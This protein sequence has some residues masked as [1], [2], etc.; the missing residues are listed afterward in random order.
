MRDVSNRNWTEPILLSTA[1]SLGAS[2]TFLDFVD[3]PVNRDIPL[4]ADPF[5]LTCFPS[6][7]AKRA[8]NQ[9]IDFFSEVLELVQ[10]QKRSQ[11]IELLSAPGEA[12]D[13]HFGYSMR[14]S[15]RRGIGKIKAE[16]MAHALFKSEAAHTGLLTSLSELDLFVDG[17]ADDNISDLTLNI[18]RHLLI[19][20]TESQLDNLD[21]EGTLIVNAGFGWDHERK[22]WSPGRGRFPICDNERILL[23]PKF[24][25]R[26]KVALNPQNFY[27]H[28]M[29]NYI[30]REHESLG[31]SFVKVFKN[32]K[33]RVLKKDVASANPFSKKSVADFIEKHPEV[34]L[35]FRTQQAASIKMISA[36][37][38]ADSLNSREII[39]GPSA[40]E[41]KS[42]L[43]GQKDASRY[44]TFILEALTF[45]CEGDLSA[46]KKEVKRDGGLGRVDIEFDNNALSGFFHNLGSKFSIVCGKIIFEC[47]NYA[48]DPKNPEIDQL[49]GRLKPHY[50][51]F[52]VLVVRHV[53]DL[54]AL[55]RRLVRDRDQHKMMIYLTDDDIVKLLG[56]AHQGKRSEISDFWSNRYAEVAN[57]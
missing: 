38:I 19:E 14:T 56:L 27:Q 46:P 7:W 4:F 29:L 16:K 1:L 43:T 55:R 6:G 37:E 53:T 3:V 33:R 54:E 50:G 9:I 24:L 15:S 32:G 49:S 47:K 39:K 22:Q 11:V 52:G 48:Y 28:W 10:Q 5:P 18:L 41:L 42:I 20:Y 36:E 44:H 34:Y 17:I 25:V 26:R 35:E 30:V 40:S 51:M 13:A 31:T 12:A 2:Q 57:T 23:V 45:I 8:N 21:I